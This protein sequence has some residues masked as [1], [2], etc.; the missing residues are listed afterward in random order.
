MSEV[1]EK[2]TK[3]VPLSL[4]KLSSLLSKHSYALI[5]TYCVGDDVY[6]IEARTPKLQ[7]TFV[8]HVPRKYKLGC[9]EDTH[10]RFQ[11]TPIPASLIS[12]RQLDYLI[13][14]KGPL[15]D[16]DLLSISSSVLCLY[17]NNGSVE[18][19]KIGDDVH[20][21]LEVEEREVGNVERIVRDASEIMKKIDPKLAFASPIPVEEQEKVLT[22]VDLEQMKMITPK[23]TE[24]M[25]ELEF[26]DEEGGSIDETIPLMDAVIS[27]DFEEP[28]EEATPIVSL[29]KI[30]R[31]DNSLPPNLEDSDITL[32]IIYYSIDVTLFYKKVTALED[33]VITIYNAID[34]NQDD[35]RSTKL[36][37]ITLLTEKIIQLSKDAAEKIKK[38]ET[39]LKSQLITLSAVLDQ[40]ETLHKR[41]EKDSKKFVAIKP[42]IDRVHNQTRSTIY[43]INVELLRIRDTAD[44]L[45]NSIQSSLE[46]I[47]N[48]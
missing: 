45:L 4:S 6:F 18:Y 12:S 36:T 37:E 15:I 40:T 35:V 29:P 38:E 32:G 22:A 11:I 34:D 24:G 31:S 2:T 43:D 41:M 16:C 27:E 8:I 10:K 17:H 3:R 47:L 21:D 9:D 23:N 1:S 48:V 5:S 42:D 25:I 20:I 28:L 44:D 30:Y 33:E 7:K 19:Y 26:E 46:E 14:A 39:E 13:D